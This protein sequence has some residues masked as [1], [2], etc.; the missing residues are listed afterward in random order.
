MAPS[1]PGP[2]HHIAPA[3]ELAGG[4]TTST[5]S[6][7]RLAED[8]FVHCS[9]SRE[10]TLAVAADYYSDV[11]EPLFVLDIDASL[12]RADL[13]FEAP[14]PLPGGGSDHLAEAETFPHVYGPIEHAAIRGV[15]L[16]VRDADGFHWPETFRPLDD[17]LTSL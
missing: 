13:R 3:S 11:S 7:A 12:L 1:S 8:G 15:G 17:V 10:V 2:I 5:Y 14:A 6:P 16:L 4:C 9:G